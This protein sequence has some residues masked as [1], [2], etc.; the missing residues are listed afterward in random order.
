[1]LEI[2][3]EFLDFMAI[4]R[5]SDFVILPL[6]PCRRPV[7]TAVTQY[8]SVAPA[9][10]V[11]QVGTGSSL[12]PDVDIGMPSKHRCHGPDSV[13]RVFL[14]SVLLSIPI[15]TDHRTGITFLDQ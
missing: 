7:R 5:V 15:D 9:L 12:N 1:V 14:F 6:E 13:M 10:Q 4:R 11:H 8:P 2:L 3:V